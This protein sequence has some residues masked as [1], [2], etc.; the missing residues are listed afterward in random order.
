M[1]I[2][3]IYIYNI[4]NIYVHIHIYI[5]IYIYIYI[6]IYIYPDIYPNIPHENGL[7]A[8]RRAL[9]EREGT[10]VL[11]DFLIELAECVLNNNIFEHNTS[12]FKQLRRTAAG[13]NMALPYAII[14]MGDLEKKI[15]KDCDK[16][17][18]TWWR[19]IDDIFM[20][21]QHGEK[22]LE[23]FLKFRNCHH[24]TIKLTANYSR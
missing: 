14:F 20:L 12:F 15:L 11:T 22:E 19:Y 17:P 18:F 2:I 16:K 23:K 13:T 4:Y 21:W 8:L 24:P 7:V 5:H 1:Y 9:D 6:F 3:Y 10:T